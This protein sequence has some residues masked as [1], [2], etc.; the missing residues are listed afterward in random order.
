MRLKDW[1]RAD[2]VRMVESRQIVNVLVEDVLRP[3]V[4]DPKTRDR[5]NFI[6][7]DSIS[8][9]DDALKI[10]VTKNNKT[11]GEMKRLGSLE[12]YE[13]TRIQVDV[14]VPTGGSAKAFRQNHEF[15]DWVDKPEDAVDYLTGRVKDL[16]VEEADKDKENSKI[17][18]IGGDDEDV[19][20]EYDQTVKV[21]IGNATLRE[22][23]FFL[24]AHE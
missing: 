12:K 8:F 21:P 6:Y 13:I 18:S 2:G 14:Q 23:V 10:G 7:S 16:A 3:N 22:R 17:R 20:L 24:V 1:S 5:S 15:P 9:D 19:V 11:P 4:E